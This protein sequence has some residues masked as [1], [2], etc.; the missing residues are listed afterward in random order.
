MR[1]ADRVDA[2]RK[3]AEALMDYRD[4]SAVVL[5]LPRGGVPVALEVAR[6][7][8]APLDLILVRKI[9]VPGHE[10][11]AA[12]AV[13]NGDEPALVRNPDVIAM[14]RLSDAFLNHAKAEKLKEIEARRQRYLGQRNRIELAGRIAII[15]DDGLATGTTAEAAIK[16]VRG[17]GAAKIVL[18]V[19]VAPADSLA[20]LRP[21][22]D[23]AICLSTPDDFAAVGQFYRHFD[24]TSDDEVIALMRQAERANGG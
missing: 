1:F 4:P 8:G 20:R 23:T 9:G 12:A 22:V 21:L 16:A 6:A 13:V 17:A 11:L 18:A 24:Q 7:I 15:V 19:P 10:E 3:L 5:A 2:G 14:A